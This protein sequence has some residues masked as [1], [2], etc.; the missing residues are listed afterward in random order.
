MAWY[1]EAMALPPYDLVICRQDPYTD[2]VFAFADETL[3]VVSDL[4]PDVRW[5][6]EP[7]HGWHVAVVAPRCFD[8][9]THAAAKAGL[10][11]GYGERR[12]GVATFQPIEVAPGRRH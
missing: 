9:V 11:V 3:E 2:V 10:R 6:R 1:S 7:R 8:E 5:K 4:F 12:D